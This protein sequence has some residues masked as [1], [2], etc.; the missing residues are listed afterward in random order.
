MKKGA[1]KSF[2]KYTEKYFCLSLIFIFIKARVG[3]L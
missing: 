3:W 2:V 1:L